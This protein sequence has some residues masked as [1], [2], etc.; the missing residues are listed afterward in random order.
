MS[1]PTDPVEVATKIAPFPEPSD[2][3]ME[4]FS[5]GSAGMVVEC[6]FCGRVY[7]ATQD[8][9][10][11][12]KGELEHYREMAEKEPNKYI[13]V[14]YFTSRIEVDGKCYAHGCECNKIRRYEDWIWHNRRQIVTYLKAVADEKYQRAKQDHEAVEA[15]VTSM[16]LMGMPEFEE[17]RLLREL[18]NKYP[19]E[20]GVYSLD[21]RSMI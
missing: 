13:E 3:F 5:G 6:D 11:F 10:D 18:L 1:D 17:R 21:S 16:K 4:A 2:E 9:G 19:D 20:N 12:E 15:T 8:H 7:F 14:A